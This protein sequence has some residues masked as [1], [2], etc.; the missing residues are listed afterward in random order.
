MPIKDKVSICS[1][2]TEIKTYPPFFVFDNSNKIHLVVYLMLREAINE[3]N[4]YSKV[5]SF[6][7]CNEDIFYTVTFIIFVNWEA[8]NRRGF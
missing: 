5:S 8:L 1:L 7:L 2:S 4:S 3:L 6:T